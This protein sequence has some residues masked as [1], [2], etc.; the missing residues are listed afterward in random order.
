M[1]SFGSK[2]FHPQVKKCHFGN[3]SEWDGMAVRSALK[4]PSQELKKLFV[5]GANEYIERLEGKIRECFFF[6]VKIKLWVATIFCLA[7][8]HIRTLDFWPHAHP[9][10]VCVLPKIQFAR[11]GQKGNFEAN[12]AQISPKLGPFLP[13]NVRNCNRTSHTQ[14]GRTHA[15]RTH[16]LEAFSHAHCTRADVRARVRVRILFRNSQ[17]A[18]NIMQ[19]NV[20]LTVKTLY[21]Y[22]PW[23]SL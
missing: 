7:R 13:K 12:F 17:I 18:I 15:H 21:V 22:Y 3:F 1:K 2:K 14:I 20:A 9:T 6:Y 23:R 10:H 16:N 5:L 8:T 4:N 11:L 19:I